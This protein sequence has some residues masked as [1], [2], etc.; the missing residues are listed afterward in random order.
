[1]FLPAIVVVSLLGTLFYHIFVDYCLHGMVC[2]SIYFCNHVIYTSVIVSHR[3][4]VCRNCGLCDKNR[5]L[6]LFCSYS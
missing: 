4:N 6:S 1:M 3:R 2:S 5:N